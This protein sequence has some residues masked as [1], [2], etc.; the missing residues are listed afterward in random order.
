MDREDLYVHMAM[1]RSK[2]RIH[3][4]IHFRTF[5]Q[6]AMERGEKGAKLFQHGP[7]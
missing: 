6:L 1:I 2:A 5:A 4:S 3:F 7:L